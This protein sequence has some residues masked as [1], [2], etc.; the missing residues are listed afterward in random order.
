MLMLR[1]IVFALCAVVYAVIY[2]YCYK[3]IHIL[4]IRCSILSFMGNFALA[5]IIGS[6]FTENIAFKGLYGIFLGSV[7]TIGFI[8]VGRQRRKG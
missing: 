4:P 5:Y 6:L 7:V 3:N 2:D 8:I 1:V